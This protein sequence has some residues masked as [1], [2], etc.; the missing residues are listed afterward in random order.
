MVT[1]ITTVSGLQRDAIAWGLKYYQA[2]GSRKFWK[3]I[4]K[5]VGLILQPAES[6]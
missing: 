4:L 6:Q 5:S 1:S 3:D 2:G